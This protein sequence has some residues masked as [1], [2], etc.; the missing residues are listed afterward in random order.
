MCKPESLPP[1]RPTKVQDSQRGVEM[2]VAWFQ[3]ICAHFLDQ[4]SYGSVYL[5]AQFQDGRVKITMD[6]KVTLQV[7]DTH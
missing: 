4:R 6:N 1:L 2:A 7:L 3:E 5:E